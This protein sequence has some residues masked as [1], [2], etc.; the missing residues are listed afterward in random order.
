[1][2]EFGE[3]LPDIDYLHRIGS[4]AVIIEN[5]RVAVVPQMNWAVLC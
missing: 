1:M 4:Y 3:K 2:K 5:E